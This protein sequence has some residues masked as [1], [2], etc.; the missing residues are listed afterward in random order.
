MEND[1][2]AITL[3]QLRARAHQKDGRQP[4]LAARRSPQSASERRRLRGDG[5]IGEP[6]YGTCRRSWCDR[7]IQNARHSGAPSGYRNRRTVRSSRR[8]NHLGG[9]HHVRSNRTYDRKRSDN[10]LHSSCKPGAVHIWVLRL[11]A[12]HDNFFSVTYLRLMRLHVGLLINFGAATFREG[13]H[14]IV[15]ELPPSASPRL[16]VNLLPTQAAP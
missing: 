12:S 1:I 15:N 8:G 11:R 6:V 13:I 7:S 10:T 4:S 9:G 14:R 16:R 2:A 3:K 5:F